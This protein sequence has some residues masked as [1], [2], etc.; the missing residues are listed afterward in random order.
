M[1]HPLIASNGNYSSAFLPNQQTQMNGYDPKSGFRNNKFVNQNS[2]LHN[3]LGNSL[4]NEEIREYSVL[5]DSKD[6]NYQV[7]PDPFDYV[8]KFNPLP[9]IV[10]I[11]NGERIVY[12]EPMPIINE[13]FKNVSYIKLE[14][15]ILP[16]YNKI[17]YVNEDVSGDMVKTVKVNVAKPLT[18]NLYIIL[19]LGNEYHDVNYKSTNDALAD[20]FAV[21]YFDNKISNTHF[22]GRCDSGIKI[23]PRDKLGTLNSLKIK[24]K[25]P[26]GEP[27]CCEHVKKEI[28]S[29]M[30]CTCNDPEGDV[31]T[32]CFKHNLFH[33][34]NPI[35]Q[36]HI[37]FK[38]GIV[39]PRLNK[40]TFN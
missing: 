29:N 20:S 11:V 15:I 19:S 39:E 40:L 36:H 8:V 17:L 30:V 26:Y 3:N 9:K 37:H 28:Q 2:L 16:F 5:I 13:D 24:F 31:F 6:R 1:S 25:D 7:Y 10:D 34:L 33:P 12:E 38:I 23:F 35:F 21:I 18:D 14:S 22:T 32:D 4:L 27:I